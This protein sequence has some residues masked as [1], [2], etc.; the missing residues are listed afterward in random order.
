MFKIAFDEHRPSLMSC[1]TNDGEVWT[2]HDAGETWTAQPPPLSGT[3]V[4]ALAR[5]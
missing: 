4:Y 2:S 5:G 3:Q 1:A